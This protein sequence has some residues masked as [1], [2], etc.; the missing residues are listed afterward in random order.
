MTRSM[1]IIRKPKRLI[2]RT[3]TKI[4][5]EGVAEGSGTTTFALYLYYGPKN[6]AP[7]LQCRLRLRHRRGSHEAA[8]N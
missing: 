1:S 6:L 5:T 2:N 7:I 8:Q 3:A 4:T